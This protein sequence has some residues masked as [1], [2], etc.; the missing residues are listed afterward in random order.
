MNF[1]NRATT[2]SFRLETG[3]SGVKRGVFFKGKKKG[4]KT[5]HRAAAVSL[6]LN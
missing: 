1:V 4:R 3:R 5:K 6:K 2:H